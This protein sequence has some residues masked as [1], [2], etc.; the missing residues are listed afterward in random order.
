MKAPGA[1]AESLVFLICTII[2]AIPV[3]I[4]PFYLTL[5]GPSHV[6]T[7]SLLA[8][9]IKNGW[10]AGSAVELNP[11]PVPN[12]TGHALIA[13]F[14]LIMSAAQAEKVFLILYLFTLPYAFRFLVM[15][16]NP[17][18]GLASFLIFPFCYS[19]LFILGFYNF[20]IGLVFLFL[21]IG[22]WTEFVKKPSLIKGLLMFFCITFTYFSHLSVYLV[23]VPV[24]AL[25]LF[26]FWLARV[27]DPD[28]GMT[29]RRF[30]AFSAALLLMLIPSGIAT[31]IFLSGK[32]PAVVG[33]LPQEEMWRNIR[34]AEPLV[35]Y[36]QSE[37]S[38][39]T[40]GF[41]NILLLLSGIVLFRRFI[42]SHYSFSGRFGEMARGFSIQLMR[43]DIWL[44]CAVALLIAYYTLPDTDGWAGYFSL[45]MLLLSF[46]FFL[47][48]LASHPLKKGVW[49]FAFAAMLYYAI[50]LYLYRDKHTA[51]LSDS[52]FHCT[53]AAASVKDKSC[54]ISLNRSGSWLL[55][56]S[57][58]YLAYKKTILLPCNGELKTG[59]FPLRFNPEQ[60]AMPLLE[61]QVGANACQP[62]LGTS[63]KITL[64]PVYIHLVGNNKP[65]KGNICD[66]LLIQFLDQKCVLEYGR[67][68]NFVY[69]YIPAGTSDRLTN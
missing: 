35:M 48:W 36:V 14:N 13:A 41:F 63:E 3:L 47:L 34:V 24:L 62:F 51:A 69:R 25:Y 59:Y 18:S 38:V 46:L 16:I 17:Q 49:V 37:E 31:L 12:W 60:D 43:H 44:L 65:E 67:D 42:C 5:D 1:K 54:V 68:F 50:P 56:H 61:G 11:F 19:Y 39:Y 2:N 52:A 27:K 4:H 20:C 26:V 6:Y 15:K 45:R 8:E 32:P 57:G 58:S 33:Y 66:S 40:R 9:M 28:A 55:G 23:M 7:A 53:A 30:S 10:D 21:T 64:H 29:F 22:L